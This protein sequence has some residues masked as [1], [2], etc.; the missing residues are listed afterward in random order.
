MLYSRCVAATAPLVVHFENGNPN[1][2]NDKVWVT[3]FASGE[4]SNFQATLNGSPVTMHQGSKYPADS[5]SPI[6]DTSTFFISEPYPLTELAGGVSITVAKSARFYI[7]LGTP[8]KTAI[9]DTTPGT[10]VLTFGAPG[11]LSGTVDPN[12]NVLW[13]F[14][15]IT[16]KG[17]AGDSGNIHSINLFAIPIK[18]QNFAAGSTIPLQTVQT[19]TTTPDVLRKLDALAKENVDNSANTPN[20]QGVPRDWYVTN[21]QGK[22]LRLVAPASGPAGGRGA[23]P[24][25]IGPYPSFNPYVDYIRSRYITTPISGTV[26]GINYRFTASAAVIPVIGSGN[27]ASIVLTGA[28]SHANHHTF[29]IVIPPDTFVGQTNANYSLSNAIYGSAY[30][31]NADIKYYRDGAEVTLG[32]FTQAVGRVEVV[33]QIFH[34][35]FSGYNFG[36]I[37]NFQLITHSDIN[38]GRPISLNDMGSEGWTKLSHDLKDGKISYEDIDLFSLSAEGKRFY[39]EWAAILYHSSKTVYGFAYSDFLQPVAL[40]TG[41]YQGTRVSS[42][43]V[44]VL[45]DSAPPSNLH[46]RMVRHSASR[47]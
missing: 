22:F 28:T 19:Y 20:Y 8:L 35:L 9:G 21:T 7:S 38:G 15:E 31:N 33:E 5:D 3:F 29:K 12:W 41:D 46:S 14:A 39:N 24:N 13:D 27:D 4:K 16:Y 30:P 47:S 36:L 45:P 42:W 43:T 34:N 6:Y 25:I 32:E 23:A 17:F 26:E 40:Q 1:Y 44:T 10:G 18:A 37:G 11:P 2:T